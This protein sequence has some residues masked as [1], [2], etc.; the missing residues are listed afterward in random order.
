MPKLQKAKSL[1]IVDDVVS[2]IEKAILAGE[3]KPG[4]KLCE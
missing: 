4:N 1:S 3:Y 2:Q